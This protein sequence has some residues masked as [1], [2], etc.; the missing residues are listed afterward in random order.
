MK[1]W[2]FEEITGKTTRALIVK[3]FNDLFVDRTG[4]DKSK[5]TSPLTESA[6]RTLLGTQQWRKDLQEYVFSRQ[7]MIETL[8]YATTYSRVKK[9]GTMV[10]SPNVRDRD[11]MEALKILG[12]EMKQLREEMAMNR[13]EP[14]VLLKMEAIDKDDP[15]LSLNATGFTTTEAMILQLAETYQDSLLDKLARM[16]KDAKQAGVAVPLKERIT[17]DVKA[18]D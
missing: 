7:R 4:R 1:E 17:I 6:L 9:L 14:I 13:L 3:Q 15:M 10:D 18:E 5:K 16:I 12:V 2:I 11:K 8:P